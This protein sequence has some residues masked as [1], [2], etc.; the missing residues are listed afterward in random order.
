MYE[1]LGATTIKG[2]ASF[3]DQHTI[4]VNNKK[5]TADNF[6]IATGKKPHPLNIPG[7][8]TYLLVLTF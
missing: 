3:V 8:S 7:H 5:I 6:V 1:G 2:E 4:E